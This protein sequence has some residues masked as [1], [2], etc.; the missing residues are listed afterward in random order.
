MCTENKNMEEKEASYVCRLCAAAS[1]QNQFH[2]TCKACARKYVFQFTGGAKITPLHPFNGWY[3]W[4]LD[5]IKYWLN[6]YTSSE[7]TENTV[8]RGVWLEYDNGMYNVKLEP[9]ATAHMPRI[10][11]RE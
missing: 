10:A 4:G 3:Y 9:L 5:N 2:P 6:P 7:P 8:M 1:A 11:E